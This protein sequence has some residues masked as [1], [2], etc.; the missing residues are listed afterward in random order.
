MVS[1][2]EN[3][4]PVFTVSVGWMM[5]GV[6]QGHL[7]GTGDS[8]VWGSEIALDCRDRFGAVEAVKIVPCSELKSGNFSTNYI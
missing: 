4:L 2:E 1:T 8:R 6:F 5:R 3:G 7:V